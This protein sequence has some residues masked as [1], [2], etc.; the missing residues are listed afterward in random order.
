MLDVYLTS[1]RGHEYWV[2]CCVPVVC[3]KGKWMV[4]G[5]CI[6]GG[7]S[8]ELAEEWRPVHLHSPLNTSLFVKSNEIRRTTTD[9]GVM[10]HAFE[11][12]EFV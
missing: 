3:V 1:Y 4:E 8:A 7:S 12:G 9:P 2:A 6:V 5:R 11:R 10:A